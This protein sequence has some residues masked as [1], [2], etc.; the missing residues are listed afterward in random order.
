VARK[1]N[2]ARLV[3]AL[4]VAG[5]LAIFLLYTS[6]VA[7]GT[8]SLQPSDLGGHTGNV[9]LG[10]LVVGRPTGNAHDT[11]LRFTIRD[12]K[13]TATVPV[14]YRGT[15]PD[16]FRTGRDVAVQGK[17]H[18]GVFV[19]ERNTLVTKCPSKYTPAKKQQQPGY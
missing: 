19:A 4:S 11:A 3:I 7:Q 15:V 6:L 1:R 2:P 12:R 10:G 17:L 14:S 18:D 8:P 9:T 5:V 13:G 16:L